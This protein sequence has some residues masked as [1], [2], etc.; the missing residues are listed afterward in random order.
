MPGQTPVPRAECK[1]AGS[2]SAMQASSNST[3]T[4]A[5]A[6]GRQLVDVLAPLPLLWPV[7]LAAGALAVLQ[8]CPCAVDE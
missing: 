4:A 3:A 8:V 2:S 6:A 7:L 5:T 1:V